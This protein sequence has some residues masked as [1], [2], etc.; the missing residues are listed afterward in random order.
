M[1][2][3]AKEDFIFEYCDEQNSRLTS[4]WDDIS[5]SGIPPPDVTSAAQTMFSLQASSDVPADPEECAAYSVCSGQKIRSCD[6]GK[7]FT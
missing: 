7:A 5:I 2:R 1:W 3:L 4:L 6:G